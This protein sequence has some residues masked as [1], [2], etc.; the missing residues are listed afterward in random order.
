MIEVQFWS[1][2]KQAYFCQWKNGSGYLN[3]NDLD[4]EEQRGEEV[5]W[6]CSR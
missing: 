1:E 5:I 6:N 4:H 2:S 3:E